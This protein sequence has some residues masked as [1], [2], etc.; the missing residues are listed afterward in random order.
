MTLVISAV[1]PWYVLQ[2]SDRWV[3]SL[4]TGAL[5]DSTANKAIFFGNR[6]AFGFCGLANLAGMRTDEWLV[7]FLDG[8]PK[9]VSLPDM[10]S[11]IAQAAELALNKMSVNKAFRHLSFIGVGWDRNT[12]DGGLQG[13]VYQIDNYFDDSYRLLDKPLPHFR[14]GPITLGP[15]ESGW[16]SRGVPLSPQ[17]KKSLH[18]KFVAC[19]RRH[20]GPSPVI[21]IF[22]DLIREKASTSSSVGKDLM[23]VVIPKTAA[24]SETVMLQSGTL[25]MPLWLGDEAQ[26]A[27][28]KIGDLRDMQSRAACQEIF[29]SHQR[30]AMFFGYM[31]DDP[32][33]VV[34]YAPSVVVPGRL[35]LSDFA[36]LAG[37]NHD[38]LVQ[39][40][41]SKKEKRGHSDLRRL[42]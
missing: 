13:V 28:D 12:V 18:R 21:R 32:K 16:I 41:L 25:R 14:V 3:T 33:E 31:D 9:N 23:F 20:L 26:A 27:L 37:P 10:A 5:M 19:A 7:N 6:M 22:S 34:V 39:Q 8:L 29:N 17:E 4:L 42:P 15:R 2:V 40:W 36:F 30:E 24:E 11:Q 38:Q 1:T 35:L